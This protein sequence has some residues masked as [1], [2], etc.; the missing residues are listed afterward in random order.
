M[1]KS[2]KP[3]ADWWRCKIIKTC[4]TKGFPHISLPKYSLK[5][6]K[7]SCEKTEIGCLAKIW[8]NNWLSLLSCFS[9]K[10][11]ISTK[12]LS[13]YLVH[14]TYLKQ[15]CL[16]I[17]RQMNRHHYCIYQ[18]DTEIQLKC[19]AWWMIHILKRYWHCGNAVYIT[20]KYNHTPPPMVMLIPWH[21]FQGEILMQSQ[22]GKE[23]VLLHYKVYW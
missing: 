18:F 11:F 12:V 6:F 5:I 22:F 14:E 1:I 2:M 9:G 13:V 16:H 19:S 7:T 23:V 4:H 3:N 21:L 15:T 20:F 10:A 8:A 17:N